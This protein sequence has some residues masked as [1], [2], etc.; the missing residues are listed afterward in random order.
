M[1]Y[2][3]ILTLAELDKAS[4]PLSRRLNP[5]VPLF[6]APREVFTSRYWAAQQVG[7]R[8]DTMVQLNGWH[9]VPNEGYVILQDGRAY[10]VTRVQQVLDADELPVTVLDLQREDDKYEI[11]RT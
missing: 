4:S 11:V 8:I 5:G 3:R 2:D 7:V 6:Y 9:D 1:I 10:R